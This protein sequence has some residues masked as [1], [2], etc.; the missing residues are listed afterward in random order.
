VFTRRRRDAILLIDQAPWHFGSAI[1]SALCRFSVPRETALGPGQG[2]TGID[3][4]HS[5]SAETLELAA[6][7]LPDA[8]GHA[9]YPTS[10][11]L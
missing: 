3:D 10:R 6:V 9:R 1:V 8:Y 2:N 5:G 4:A 11:S 7:M